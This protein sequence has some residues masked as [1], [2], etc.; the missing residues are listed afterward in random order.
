LPDFAESFLK[1]D[2]ILAAGAV[3][4]RLS[5]KIELSTV[6]V[7]RRIG[8]GDPEMGGISRHPPDFIGG[9]PTWWVPRDTMSIHLSI[10]IYKKFIKHPAIGGSSVVPFLQSS[11]CFPKKRPPRPGKSPAP[12]VYTT[13]REILGIYHENS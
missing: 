1:G 4:P 8:S 10:N 6:R 3:D 9:F 11:R 13:N 5:V 2:P 12:R 7:G